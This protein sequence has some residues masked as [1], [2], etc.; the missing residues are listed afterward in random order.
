MGFALAIFYFYFCQPTLKSLCLGA[1]L[2]LSGVI[3]RA[4]ASGHLYKNQRIATSGPYASTRNP[5]YVGSFIIGLGFCVIAGNYTVAAIFIPLFA[6]VYI[7]V[8]LQETKHL[9]TLFGQEYSQ[10]EAEVPLFFPR[11]TPFR[12]SGDHFSFRQY[13]ANREYEALLG[14]LGALA[15]LLLKMGLS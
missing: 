11:L 12:R 2:A 9:R 8:M 4:W 5:L 10:Y 13:L 14:Y 1:A 3:L 7:P 15:I 6:A